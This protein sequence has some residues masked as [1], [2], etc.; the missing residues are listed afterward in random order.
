[1]APADVFFL[2]NCQAS[3]MSQFYGAFTPGP[4]KRSAMFRSITPHFGNYAED[5]SKDALETA[6]I[7][8][9][10]LI[11][12]D[13]VFNRQAVLEMRGGKPTI[14]L[15]YVYLP[16]FRRLEKLSSKGVPRIDGADILLA[17]MDRVGH[18]SRA[19]LAFMRGTVDMQ[20][21][22]RLDAALA[23]LKRREA[24]GADIT[25]A[26]YI[27]QTY[28]DQM[29]CF[30]INHPTPHVL[31]EMYNQVAKLA[32][33]AP[34]PK[35]ISPYD[36]GRATLPAGNGGLTPYCVAALGL[37]YGPEAQWFSATN[38]NAQDLVRHWNKDN[39]A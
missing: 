20:N 19:A 11:N 3:R 26:D 16:G 28:R 31:F 23:E 2:G 29:P 24:M 34:V 35:T 12:A 33:F 9:V 22:T 25:I 14:F 10:Q 30:S 5:E 17:E 8:V 1:M 15:P 18:A 38:K 36:M 39:A 37:S 13:Y 7:A 4:Q 6:A 27:A 32:G 21:Q